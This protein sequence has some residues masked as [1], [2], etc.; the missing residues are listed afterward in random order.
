MGYENLT[1]LQKQCLI[2]KETLVTNDF[3]MDGGFLS[4]SFGYGSCLDQGFSNHYEDVVSESKEEK[5]LGCQKI[6]ALICDKC[7]KE[8]IDHF[9]GYKQIKETK[10]KKVI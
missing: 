7:F 8:N 9:S 2:C 1:N 3:I 6:E 10:T 4:A 5:L